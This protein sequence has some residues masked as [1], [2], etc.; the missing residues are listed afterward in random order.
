MTTADACALLKEDYEK[1]LQRL[2]YEIADPETVQDRIPY[3]QKEADL[4]RAWVTMLQPPTQ[5]APVQQ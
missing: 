5:A 1:K 4:C 3:L 2:E